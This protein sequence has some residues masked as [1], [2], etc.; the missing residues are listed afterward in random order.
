[1]EDGIY[2]IIYYAKRLGAGNSG[3]S[4]CDSSL[5]MT[6][7]CLIFFSKFYSIKIEQGKENTRTFTWSLSPQVKNEVSGTK[8]N[9]VNNIVH[10]G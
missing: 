7:C 6:G 9:R 3:F 10:N 4:S 8:M 5:R 1:M 2:T